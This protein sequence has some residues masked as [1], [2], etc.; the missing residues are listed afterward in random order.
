MDNGFVVFFI[1][2][3][4]VSS[5]IVNFI[6]YYVFLLPYSIFKSFKIIIVTDDT[7]VIFGESL[8]KIAILKSFI[9]KNDLS[10]QLANT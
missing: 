10:V 4:F 3:R 5:T 1:R 9:A 6:I 8:S 7:L 2:P